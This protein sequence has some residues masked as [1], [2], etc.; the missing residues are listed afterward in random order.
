MRG[1]QLV[2]KIG[3]SR[4]YKPTQ[5]GLRAMAALAVLQE[6]VIKPLLAASCHPSVRPDIQN[7]QNPTTVDQHYE[8]LR[9]G[10]QGLFGALGIAA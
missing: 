6:K 7:P 9:F 5:K 10:L 1:K 3:N 2:E 8:I 4:R